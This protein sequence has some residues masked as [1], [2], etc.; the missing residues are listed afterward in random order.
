MTKVALLTCEKFP[1]LTP[2]DQLLIPALAK[3]KIQAKVEIWDNASVNWINYDYLIFRN[4]WDYYEKEQQFNLWLDQI[5][6]LG[7]KTLNSLDI[8]Q[9]NKHKFYLK[10]LQ[11]KGVNIIPTLFQKK[12]N[13]LDLK[14]IIPKHWKKI[15]IKPAFSAGSYL[16]EVFDATEIEN[17]NSKYTSIASQKELLIQEFKS[18]IKIEG[19]TSF[20]FFNKQFSHCVNKKPAENDFRIQVQFGGKYTL[21]QP[22]KALIEQAQKIVNLFPENLLYTRVDGIII[23]NQIHLMEVECIEP[24]L[25]FTL[26]PNALDKFVT[27][28]LELIE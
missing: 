15:V 6:K 9:E 18:E 17:I 1:L 12:T 7:I 19:E 8:I 3:H 23:D 14:S 21:I 13:Q 25:Y 28:I 27:S 11:E 5:E 2:S 24:D 4:T 10:D 22:S 16:T 26:A 20:L